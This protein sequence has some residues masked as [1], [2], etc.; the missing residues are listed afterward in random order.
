[1]MFPLYDLDGA[2]LGEFPGQDAVCQTPGCENNGVPIQVA[3]HPSVTVLC[4]PCGQW[5]I[6]PQIEQDPGNV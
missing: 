5:I 2:Y 1:M 3:D 6:P 4:G